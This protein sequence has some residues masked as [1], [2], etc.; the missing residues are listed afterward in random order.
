MRGLIGFGIMVLL[1]LALLSGGAFAAAEF[2]TLT[3]I[4]S[5][6]FLPQA[7]HPGDT[8]SMAV[9]IKNRGSS[10]D[11]S[12]LNASVE[13]DSKFMPISISERI[14]VIKPGATRTAIFGF[15]ANDDAAPGYYQVFLTL[16]YLRDGK[17]V[18]ERTSI[19][20]P[21]SGTQRNLDV[22]ISPRTVNP[23][24]QTMMGFTLKNIGGIPVSNISFAW[25]EKNALV[26]PLGTDNKRYIESLGPG[27]AQDINYI[28]AADPNIA[29]GI[30]PLD[31]TLSFT[32]FNGSKTQNS[33]V[34][35]II[36]GGTDFEVSAE[37]T[38][39]GQLSL[40]VANIGSNNAGA[41]VVKIPDQPNVSVLGSN[42]SIIG[43]LNKGDFSL[44]NFS[45]RQNGA[46]DQNAFGAAGTGATGFRQ[47]ASADAPS[48]GSGTPTAQE[49]QR[50][51]FAAG[52]M[53]A[54]R[55]SSLIMQISYTDTTGERVTIEK[56][57]R[58]N[59]AAT[60]AGAITGA[61]ARQG[62]AA[63]Y[64]L[65][66]IALLVLLAGGAIVYNN[67]RAK[68]SWGKMV[69][70][71]GAVVALFLAAVLLLRSSLL[72]V[73]GAVLISAAILHIAFKGKK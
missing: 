19:A 57:V 62:A 26:L 18:T 24:N 28:V 48:S 33:Q 69:L 45:I 52:P 54:A 43:N 40:S 7:I 55:G 38:A 49:G 4:S 67:S 12:D 23:G 20:V 51:G 39:A 50:Q 1:A 15:R 41:V 22:S 27:E 31:I 37:A 29:P 17:S 5:T 60:T 16:D 2:G 61:G 42:A 63:D 44:A 30:Y 72:A 9:A 70:P 59:S 53:G 3:E 73:V 47:R 14:D 36:G 65:A 13:L 11:V 21:V 46:L 25:S 66:A 35:L 58:L 64:Q 10:I 32:D 6:S 8:I 56:T 71:I 34:G 68:I